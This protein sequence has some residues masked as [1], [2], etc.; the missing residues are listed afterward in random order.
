MFI[1]LT[2][3]YGYCLLNMQTVNRI[4]SLCLVFHSDFCYFCFCLR[5]ECLEEQKNQEVQFVNNF[6]AH[7]M[8]DN[9]LA[10]EKLEY[11]LK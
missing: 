1:H 2:A 9:N 3:K 7:E 6:K 10:K 11:L 5:R 8:L 4:V